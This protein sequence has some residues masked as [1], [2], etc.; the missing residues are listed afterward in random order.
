MLIAFE[1]P[2]YEADLAVGKRTQTVRLGVHGAFILHTLL[3]LGALL[4]ILLA[5]TVTPYARYLWLAIPLLVWQGFLYG[6]S[7]KARSG[8]RKLNLLTM[9]AVGLFSLTTG[10]WFAGFVVVGR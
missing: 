7:S 6:V 5:L 8:W 3:L 9:G 2:D 10:L 1:L 4:S